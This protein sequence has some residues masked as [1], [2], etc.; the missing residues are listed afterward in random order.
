[1]RRWL[2]PLV[3]G[4]LVALVA[5]SR[6][7]WPAGIFGGLSTG[8]LTL[9]VGTLVR[10]RALQ[11]APGAPALK[12]HE[13]PLLHGPV[14][15]LEK[16]GQRACWAYLSDQR[17]NIF[18]ADGGEGQEWAL[19]QLTELRPAQAGIFRDGPLGLVFNGQLWQMKVPD[20]GR[21]T[22]ALQQAIHPGK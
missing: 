18:P 10:G 1:M 11:K 5:K 9:Y 22:A 6:A 17:L 4:L 15:V 7:G 3:L 8:I 20:A 2:S 21:W 16:N 13:V 19:S 14:E 12:A